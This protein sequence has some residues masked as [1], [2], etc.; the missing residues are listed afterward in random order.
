MSFKTNDYQQITLD[1]NLNSNLKRMDSLMI[2][3]NCK[4][5]SRLELVYTVVANAVKLLDR[6]GENEL[7]PTDMVHYLDSDDHN[8]VIYY[9]KNEDV[10][11]RLTTVINDAGRMR[12]LMSGDEW[13]QLSEYQ[14][15]SSVLCEQAQ[16]ETDGCM[17]EAGYKSK[18][19]APQSLLQFYYI[20]ITK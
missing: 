19:L 17:N 4:R 3:S 15:L 1:L 7:I 10:T 2:A 6:L 20:V 18:V 8:D 13:L 11:D 9:S 5:M 16:E 14:L 12:N